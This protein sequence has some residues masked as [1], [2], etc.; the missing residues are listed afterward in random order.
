MIG[1]DG[2][3]NGASQ[4]SAIDI[5]LGFWCGFSLYFFVLSSHKVDSNTPT[6]QKLLV[7]D[8]CAGVRGV[9]PPASPLSRVLGR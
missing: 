3:M 4:W 1:W 9:Q 2:G 7:A 6:L 8:L 5:F